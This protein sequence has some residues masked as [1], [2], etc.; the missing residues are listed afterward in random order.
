M[1]DS[2]EAAKRARRR[3]EHELAVA[4]RQ[5]ADLRRAVADIACEFEIASIEVP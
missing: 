3:R 5:R 4:A 2:S 1:V